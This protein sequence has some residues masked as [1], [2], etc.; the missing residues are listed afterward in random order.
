MSIEEHPGGEMLKRC[1]KCV[2]PETYPGI[3]FNEHGVCSYCLIH[4]DR[5]PWGEA[6]LKSLVEPYRERGKAYGCMV[7]LSGG[8]DS[9]FA[10]NYAVK[11]LGL[12]PLLFTFDNGFMPDQTKE[13]IRNTVA[14]LGTDHVVAKRDDMKKS[15]KCFLSAWVHTP[16]PAMIG[17]LCT[18]CRTGYLQELVKTVRAYDIPL[19]ITGAGEPERSFAE[20]LLSSDRSRRRMLPL[21]SGFA[22]QVIKEPRYISS[23]SFLTMVAKEFFFRFLYKV[24]K[25]VRMTAIFRYIEWDEQKIAST[26][27]RELKWKKPA[28][29]NSSWRADCKLN[30]LKN[31]M[32]METLGFTKHDELLSGMI[33]RGLLTRES[34]L[35]RLIADNVI[36]RAFLG[37]L[38]SGLGLDYRDLETSLS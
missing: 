36:S 37:E 16:S 29:S 15:V 1:S 6:A 9:T 18:G 38:C 35:Q 2:L 23:I 7:A 17:L 11:V 14:M 22:A 24:K 34:A 3:A 21:L 5:T 25:Q 12:K 28:Y 13:N 32:Y 4:R 20:R 10:A 19:V 27:E 31:Y 33:R 8:R 26:I 30:E